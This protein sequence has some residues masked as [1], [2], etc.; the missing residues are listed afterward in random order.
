[1]TKATEALKAE[2]LETIRAMLPAGTDVY[3]IVRHVSAS[4]MSRQISFHVVEAGQILN[5]T[6]HVGNV[7]GYKMATDRAA[8]KVGGAGMDMCFAVVYGLGRALFPDGYTLPAGQYGRNG[9]PSTHETDGG[10]ALNS[11]QL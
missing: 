4:G 10:Y 11:R 9:N 7:L 3:C 2:S 8:L 5:I 1:M 6:Y